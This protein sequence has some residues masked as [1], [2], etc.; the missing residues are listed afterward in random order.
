MIENKY[1][2][3]NAQKSKTTKVFIKAGS[4]FLKNLLKPEKKHHTSPNTFVIFCQSRSKLKAGLKISKTDDIVDIP[5]TN[6]NR[7]CS[8]ISHGLYIFYPIFTAT[9]IVEQLVLQTICVLNNSSILEPK[10]CGL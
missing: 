5:I 9:Y 2:G 3:R 10:F 7:T 8:I 1:P 4:P 6:F